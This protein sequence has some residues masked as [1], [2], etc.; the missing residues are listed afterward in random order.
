MKG[1]RLCTFTEITQKVGSRPLD[2]WRYTQ[3]QHFTQTLPQLLRGKGNMRLIEK[4]FSSP[5]CL[6]QSTS[7]IYKILMEETEPKYPLY[8]GKWEEEIGALRDEEHGMKI[9]SP[10][11]FASSDVKTTEMC[12]KLLTRWYVTPQRAQKLSAD[13]PPTCWRGCDA[14]GTFAQL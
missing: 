8:L 2:R 11:C 13:A 9:L 1:N 12:Y 7:N 14:L 6:E 3:I 5:L 4:L 10:A